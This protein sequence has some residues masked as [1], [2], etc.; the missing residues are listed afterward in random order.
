M[1]TLL[2]SMKVLLAALLIACHTETPI[3]PD[4]GADAGP[5]AQRTCTGLTA[6]QSHAAAIGECC[7]PELA[8]LCGGAQRG[9]CHEGTCVLQCSGHS[10]A[11]PSDEQETWLESQCVCL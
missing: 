7:R 5:D 8:P 6:E 10:P 2:P 11:C 3:A 9:F 4:A 1:V